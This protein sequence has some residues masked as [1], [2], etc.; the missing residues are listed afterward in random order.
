MLNVTIVPVLTD[1]YSYILQSGDAVAV[2]DPGEP[3]PLEIKLAEMGLTPTLILNTHHHADHIAGNRQLKKKYGCKVIGPIADIKRMPDMD[4]GVKE[5]SKIQLG[6]ETLRVI[7]TPGHTSGHICFYGEQSHILFAGDTL[8]S[9][10]CGRLVEGTADQM[11]NSLEK[12]MALPDETQIYCG[13]EYTLVNAKFC[14]AVEKNNA[15]IKERLS[16]VKKLTANGKPTIPSTL[17]QEKKTNVFLR[18][19]KAASFTQLRKLKDNF[20]E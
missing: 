9:M 16:E 18:T 4:E 7:E 8:F 17:A 20:Q 15:D 1:N 13:H 3:G 10:G 5:G 12:I 2:M 6:D 11:W 14:H 19:G